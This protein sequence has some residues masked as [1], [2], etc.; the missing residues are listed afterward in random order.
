MITG[1]E[2]AWSPRSWRLPPWYYCWLEVFCASARNLST[3]LTGLDYGDNF[4]TRFRMFWIYTCSVILMISGSKPLDGQNFT[5]MSSYTT[6]WMIRPQLIISMRP[7]F[8][9]SGLC[10]EWGVYSSFA[11]T[12]QGINRSDLLNYRLHFH[13]FEKNKNIYTGTWFLSAAKAA[14]G[15]SRTV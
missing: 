10:Y 7:D 11:H 14:T 15:D 9:A 13:V 2:P 3:R 12:E 4:P 8:S 1:A 6:D 5:F